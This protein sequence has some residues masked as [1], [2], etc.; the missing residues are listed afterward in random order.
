MGCHG[1]GAIDLCSWPLNKMGTKTQ[2]VWHTSCDGRVAVA[3]AYTFPNDDR[4]PK[5]RR[6]TSPATGGTDTLQP[7]SVESVCAPVDTSKP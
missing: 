1:D 4:F 6:G 3:G 5:H 2:L 7:Q